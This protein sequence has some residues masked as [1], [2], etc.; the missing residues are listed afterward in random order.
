M[1]IT[2]DNNLSRGYRFVKALMAAGLISAMLVLFFVPPEN[3]PFTACEFYSLTGH[4]C[5]TC[6]MTRS[7]HA[8]SHGDLTGSLRYHLMGPAV[9]I[10]VLLSLAVL[11]FEAARGK[12]LN[13]G[14]ERRGRWQTVLL[15]AAV[16]FLYWGGRLVAEF[17]S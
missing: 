12:R 11:F 2:W 15:F 3:I 1:N 14:I 10:L 5:L 17:V 9:F 8:I 16:W 6:G 13:L 4:S 7:L